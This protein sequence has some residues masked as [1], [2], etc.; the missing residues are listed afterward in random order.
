VQRTIGVIL[1]GG[2]GS[3]LGGGVP[4]QLLPLAGKPLME[5]SVAAFQESGG[6]DEIVIVMQ[7]D[8]LPQAET[9]AARYQKIT[10][11]LPGGASRTGSTLA[12]LEHLRSMAP[13]TK[14]LIHDAAR[15]LVTAQIIEA[16]LAALDT[17]DA[18]SVA[19]PSH[20]TIF[21]VGDDGHVTSVLARQRLRRVQTPQGFRLGTIS[22][23]YG[24]ALADPGFDQ[25]TD[26]CSVVLCYL[27]EVPIAVIDGSDANIKVTTAQDFSLAE[28]LLAS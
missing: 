26:D 2:I 11:V 27:P 28:H 24:Q 25:A 7:P 19:V 20:D 16:V 4:K 22:R 12:A 14:V 8:Y 3:R 9:M 1:A 13:A 18:A 5:H 23:A 6:I 10:K 15:P 17:H 21:E